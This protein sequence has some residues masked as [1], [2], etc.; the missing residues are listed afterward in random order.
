MCC[1]GF[2]IILMFSLAVISFVLNDFYPTI[3]V[4]LW[5][6]IS[7]N[8][9]TFLLFSIDKYYSVKKRKRV[10]E[11]SLHFFSLAGGIFGALIAM[12]VVKHKIRKKIFLSIQIIIAIIWVISIYYILTNLETIQNALQSLSA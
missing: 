4:I 9:F 1:N 10:P 7:I 8:L 12:V 3:P 5:Y 6:L 2:R 11:I